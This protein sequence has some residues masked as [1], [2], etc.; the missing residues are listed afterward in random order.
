MRKLTLILFL[1]ISGIVFCQDANEQELLKSYSQ[2]ELSEIKKTNQNN[3]DLL[4]FALE[5]ALEVMELPTG[6][7][8]KISG[9]IK[10]PTAEDTF[11][12][13]G[14]K[15]SESNQYFKITGTNKM[16]LVKS[17]YTLKTMS[18]AKN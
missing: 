16:L 6:K 14:L 7:S 9:E 13:L 2:A 11:A 10:L 5:N 18:N 3:Y 15:I 17:F 1:T 4:S 12:S 8:A